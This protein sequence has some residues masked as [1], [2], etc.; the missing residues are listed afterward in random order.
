LVN[1]KLFVNREFE[2]SESSRAGGVWRQN[3][4]FSKM[5]SNKRKKIPRIFF[6][7]SFTKK[8]FNKRFFVQINILFE[9]LIFFAEQNINIQDLFFLKREILEESF[10]FVFSRLNHHFYMWKAR[11]FSSG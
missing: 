9:E 3:V 2:P 8:K 1:Q 4:R 5:K 11:L 10:Q 7:I 6:S